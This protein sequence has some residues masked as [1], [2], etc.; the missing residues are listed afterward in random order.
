MYCHEAYSSLANHIQDVHSLFHE[1]VYH[2][3]FNLSRISIFYVIS[4]FERVNVLSQYLNTTN[5]V[6]HMIAF[7]FVDISS[8]YSNFKGHYIH[9]SAEIPFI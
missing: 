9:F 8:E 6:E 3:N 7:R 5:I 1:N 4:N 2:E